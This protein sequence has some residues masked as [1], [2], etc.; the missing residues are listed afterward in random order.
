M[1]ETRIDRAAMGRLAIA[2]TFICGPD[3]PATMALE[4]AA[5]RGSDQDIKRARELFL[6]LSPAK[7]QAALNMLGD[8]VAT[9]TAQAAAISTL[10]EG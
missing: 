8:W 9:A 4:A 1:D 3:H 7:R 5:E 6:A 10:L 2:L